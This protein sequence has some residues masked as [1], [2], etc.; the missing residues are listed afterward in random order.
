MIK[1]L[2]VAHYYNH[3]IFSDGYF[4]IVLQVQFPMPFQLTEKFWNKYNEVLLAYGAACA[5]REAYITE[6]KQ[7]QQIL[8]HYLNTMVQPC[9]V[10]RCP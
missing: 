9:S 10:A 2:Y 3:N 5:Q 6:N 1:E 7:L 4:F 8:C